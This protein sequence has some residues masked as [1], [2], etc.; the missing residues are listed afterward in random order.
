MLRVIS[1]IFDPLGL[2]S[3][4][5]MQ[6][7]VHFQSATQLKLKW[8]DVVP[9]DLSVLW[10][11]WLFEFGKLND[12]AFPRCLIPRNYSDCYIELH[13][14]SDA[15]QR[16][17]GAC[18]YMRLVNAR[19]EISCSLVAAKGHVAPMKTQTIPRLELQ[20]AVQSVKLCA[21]V[22][23]ALNLPMV[24]VFYWTDSMIVLG[25]ITNETRRF[26][27]FVAN[28]VSVIRSLSRVCDWR[29]I[30]GE[31]NPADL[32]TKSR[33]MH[34]HLDL[35]MHGPTFLQRHNAF[36]QQSND[37]VVPLSDDDG[38]VLLVCSNL[39]TSDDSL[40]DRI[41]DHHSS[42][43]KMCR[44]IAW[45][46]RF[47]Q[48]LKQRKARVAISRGPL[49]AS[50]LCEARNIIARHAQR[51]SF[52]REYSDLLAGR[53]LAASSRL[54]G[55]SPTLDSDGLLRVGG[56]I[57]QHPVLLSHDSAVARAIVGHF[58]GQTHTGVEWTLAEI[59]KQWWI[60]RARPLVK[61]V[62][63]ACVTC[64]RLYAK[65]P[66]QI[67]STLPPE[68]VSPNL[69]P[70]T[71]IGLD[72]FGPFKVSYRRSSSKKYGCIFTCMSTRAIHLEVLDSLDADS[73]ISCL[74]RFIARRGS[75]QKIFSD[76]GT[77]FV[78][79]ERE[80]RKCAEFEIEW[81]F[82]PPSAPHMGGVWERLVGV[83]KRVLKAVLGTAL[84]LTDEIFATALCEV[85]AIVNGRPLTKLSDD[86]NDLSPLT[87]AHLLLL[88]SG[89]Q[90]APCTGSV[91][92]VYR[93]R[94][95]YVQHLANSFWQ[96]WVKE[97]LPLLQKR[98]KWF[99][100][101]ENVKIGELVLIAEKGM[102][103]NLWPM[104]RIIETFPGRDGKVRHVLLKTRSS[105]SLRR[106]IMTCVRLEIDTV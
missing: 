71:F 26:K 92:D 24:P 21:L 58:H 11:N 42:W 73:F 72:V 59:R 50:E 61:Q 45:L 105:N 40:I 25:Y 52:P 19:G 36:W 80:L 43:S 97:Y 102:P 81:H 82:I 30:D 88:R 27:T 38:E 49:S 76:N 17:Y 15:S 7:R 68:R 47:V 87:P 28:R 83:V 41:C 64:K 22:R 70:F 1:A 86:V 79:G 55:L 100:P 46:M 8:D 9:D 101:V 77:N 29:H 51:A 90:L 48:N 62:T 103:R 39:T 54:R 44:S 14:F 98:T 3:P 18:I 96:R 66:S 67:M 78:A 23:K 33:P 56:R 99:D 10:Q 84:R 16:A 31:N 94:W 13:V 5:V 34:V 89:T 93:R 106:P 91:S 75:P 104:G 6:A 57:E 95:R 20:G 12:I 2:I 85:E 74:R 35:W 65:P 60:T 4:W 32:I 69:P 53:A 63:R 37:L